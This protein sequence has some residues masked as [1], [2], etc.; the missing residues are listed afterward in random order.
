[1]KERVFVG[2]LSEKTRD[3]KLVRVTP[4]CFDKKKGCPPYGYYHFHMVL[5]DSNYF[6]IGTLVSEFSLD[7]AASIGAEMASK[8]GAPCLIDID[9]YSIKRGGFF[10][11]E[12]N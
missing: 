1:M 8:Y 9:F 11:S 10:E 2:A 7:E 6:L 4:P 3:I 5:S 12:N